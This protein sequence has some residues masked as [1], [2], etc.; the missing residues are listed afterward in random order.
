ML[1]LHFYF[2]LFFLIPEIP[3][4]VH[5]MTILDPIP[6]E[7]V[8]SLSVLTIECSFSGNPLPK[9]EWSLEDEIFV[10]GKMRGNKDP[11]EGEVP[12]HKLVG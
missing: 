12:R 11:A 2:C 3:P 5:A 8:K 6:I 9:I 10:E 7:G 1:L 4:R